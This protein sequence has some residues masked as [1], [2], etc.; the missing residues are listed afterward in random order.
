MM[1][2][3]LILSIRMRL[4]KLYERLTIDLYRGKIISRGEKDVNTNIFP[5]LLPYDL[6]VEDEDLHVGPF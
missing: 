6:C 5:N 3:T 2:K 4:I 1:G